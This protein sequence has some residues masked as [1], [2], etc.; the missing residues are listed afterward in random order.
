MV[1]EK[2][3][4]KEFAVK[5]DMNKV[6]TDFISLTDE[7]KNKELE[8]VTIFICRNGREK[9]RKIRIKLKKL[10]ESSMLLFKKVTILMLMS[11]P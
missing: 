7:N 1:D 8:E 6:D 9:L 5:F 2:N 3:I 10:V 11:I 4:D